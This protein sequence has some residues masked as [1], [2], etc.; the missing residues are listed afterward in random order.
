MKW[1][2]VLQVLGLTTCFGC[3]TPSAET[4]NSVE[5]STSQEVVHVNQDQITDEPKNSLPDPLRADGVLSDEGDCLRLVT[6][7]LVFD[8]PD[9]QKAW[10]LYSEK[11]YG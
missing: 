6:Q 8:N 2:Y 5:T 1:L 4:P 11:K 7:D 3:G 10:Q 9:A